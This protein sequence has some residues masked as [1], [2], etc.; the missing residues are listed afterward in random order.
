[1]GQ[2][3]TSFFSTPCKYC[4]G[5]FSTPNYCNEC[6]GAFKFNLPECMRPK[7]NVKK[8]Q[9]RDDMFEIR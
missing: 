1:M 3:F 6:K 5:D 4:N 9:Y 7:Q 2:T 8:P